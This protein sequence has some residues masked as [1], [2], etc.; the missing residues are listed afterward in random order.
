MGVSIA[1]ITDEVAAF[2]ADI[3]AT[4][5]VVPVGG[6]TQWDVGGPPD[7][8]AREVTAPVGVIEHEPAEL[9]VRCNAG[10]TIAELNTTLASHDQ[11]VP[12]D[13]LDQAATVGGFIAVGASGHRRLRY[14]HARDLVLQMQYVAHD[15]SVV[16]AGGPTVKNVSGY[17]LCRLL[18]GSLGTLGITAEVIL[19][20]LPRPATSRWLRGE[21]DPFDLRDRLYRPSSILWDG[22]TTWLLLEGHTA[23]VDSESEKAGLAQC[24]GPP[25]LPGVGRLSMRP[26]ELHGLRPGAGGGFI[27]EI[28]VGV[29]HQHEPVPSRGP[30]NLELNRE[31]KRRFDPSGRLNPSRSMLG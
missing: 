26:S 8:D 19:R 21:A 11:M 28:G 31:L 7:S 23:D 29:V 27:A 30:G 2:A 5:P 17:D 18:V 10:T 12:F 13:P 15:G 4:D 16:T 25:P 24:D 1:P 9:T 22:T 20:C 6:R 3:G 14:G